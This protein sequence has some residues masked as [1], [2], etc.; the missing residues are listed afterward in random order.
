MLTAAQRVKFFKLARAAFANAK[1]DKDFDTWRH[2]EMQSACGS[3]SVFACGHTWEYDALM[4][5]F[6]VLACDYSAAA[7]FA[8]AE[9][10][11]VRWVLDGL[12]KDLEFLQATGVDASYIEGIYR[13][14]G[15]Q[16]GD[17]KDGTL[18]DL[19]LL[20]PMLDT[21]IRHLARD[22][23]ADLKELPTAGT[24]W[25]FR[26]QGAGRFRDYM[27]RIQQQQDTQAAASGST[28]QA[29]RRVPA[30]DPAPGSAGGES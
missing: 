19:L 2:E 20:I 7:Y 1:P 6:A 25:Y 8:D 14:A 13:Q 15:F 3:S 28:N 22:V 27:S 17:F 18:R 16:P 21:R 30:S 12:A 9:E 4:R 5:H 10:R 26:G 24:P 11:R 23:G 29:E